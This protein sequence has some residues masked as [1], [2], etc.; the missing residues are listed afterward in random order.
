[1]HLDIDSL[2]PCVLRA[3]LFN[4]YLSPP[5]NRYESRYESR[6]VY[7]YEM[8]Y[9][10]DSRGGIIVNGE[11]LPTMPG[12]VNLRKPGEY[13]AGIPPYRCY[14]ICFDVTG[15][16][17]R[18]QPYTFGCPEEAQPCYKNPILDALPSK[19]SCPPGSQIEKL[20]EK[21]CQLEGSPDPYARFAQRTALMEILCQLA[22][23][24]QSSHTHI[25][26]PIQRVTRRISTHFAEPLNVEQ[27]IFESGMS[28]A[29]FHRR[30]LSETGRT[31][32]EMITEL[33][34]ARAREMLLLTDAPVADIA[35]L[36]GY[37]DN[38]YFAR[39]FKK[40]CGLSPLDF[41]ASR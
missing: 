36:C 19:I 32:L 17:H 28:H 41:R 23:F 20:F 14:L 5:F 3:S 15:H 34:M 8:E 7:D 35:D 21:V 9:Y 30:F 6:Y 10:T 18:R 26:P 25:S 37:P 38:S 29:T 2:C 31:P 24:A 16:P 4:G 33:R 12:D 1:M 39:V 11:Y 22:G 27:L 40:H 13:V